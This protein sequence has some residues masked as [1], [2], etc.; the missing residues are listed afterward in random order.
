MLENEFVYTAK[1]VGNKIFS[2]KVETSMLSF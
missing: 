2:Y 1:F